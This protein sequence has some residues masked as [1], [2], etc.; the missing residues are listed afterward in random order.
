MN[1]PTL[2]L[3]IPTLL[4]EEVL[5]NILTSALSQSVRPDEIIVADQTPVHEP[6]TQKFLDD[7]ERDKK[8][9]VLRLAKP[10]LTAAR[11]QILLQA[12]SDFVL[13]IDDDLV[14]PHDFIARYKERLQTP[15]IALLTG[16]ILTP[17]DGKHPSD[18]L[19]EYLGEHRNPASSIQTARRIDETVR[20]GN[21]A[22][23]TSA[24]IEAL[25]FDENLVGPAYGEE[26]DFA[27]RLLKKNYTMIYDESLPVLHL[28]VP[29]GGCRIVGNKEWA[30]WQ[31][32]V[33]Q[34]IHIFR[35]SNDYGARYSKWK[36]ALRA[37]PLRKENVILPW[38]QP[39][40]WLSFFRAMYEA[41]RRAPKVVS[42]FATK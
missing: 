38:R 30:E 16:P 40:A 18:V 5:V 20:G 3:G 7:A 10:S 12:S 35:H 42:P 24:A 11:N 9:I 29:Y 39:G 37:G 34:L 25:G 15:G 14:L 4:R 33:N 32:S 28:M 31:K 41:A 19:K 27:R 2:T 23:R 26:C 17:R 13:F 21:V 1:S 8:I 22:V 6:E 36:M